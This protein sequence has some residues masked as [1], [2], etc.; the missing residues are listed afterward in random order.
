VN[1]L[2]A[3]AL[4]SPWIALEGADD[5][6]ERAVLITGAIIMPSPTAARMIG[7]NTPVA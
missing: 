6:A 4:V 5:R 1:V 2:V 7:P 3:A